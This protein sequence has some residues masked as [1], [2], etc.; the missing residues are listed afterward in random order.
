MAREATKRRRGERHQT[1]LLWLTEAQHGE[2]KDAAKVAET[3]MAGLV[4]DALAAHLPRLAKKQANKES[5]AA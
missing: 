4:R 3:S 2:L 5:A 1:V